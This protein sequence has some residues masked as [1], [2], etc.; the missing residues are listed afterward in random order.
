MAAAAELAHAVCENA[1][2]AVRESLSIARQSLDLT[3]AELMALSVEAQGRLAVT[4]D[5]AEGPR[6]FL[7]RRKPRWQA[8]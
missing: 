8:R 6:A 4:E 1:P 3:D 5:F 7:E 2:L